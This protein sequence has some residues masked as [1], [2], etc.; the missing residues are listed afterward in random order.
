MVGGAMVRTLWQISRQTRERAVAS[1]AVSSCG[2]A[3]LS[4]TSKTATRMEALSGGNLFAGESP[5]R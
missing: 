5:V 4:S 2:Q 1:L 3:R